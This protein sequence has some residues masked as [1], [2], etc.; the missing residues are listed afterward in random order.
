VLE[1]E[2]DERERRFDSAEL[3]SDCDSRIRFD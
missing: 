2:T 3:A 1:L